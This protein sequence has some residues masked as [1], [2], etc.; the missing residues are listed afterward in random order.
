[1][2][3]LQCEQ[4]EDEALTLNPDP[5]VFRI[6]TAFPRLRLRSWLRRAAGP[7]QHSVELCLSLRIQVQAM[8]R[9]HIFDIV[10]RQI[11]LLWQ[12][13]FAK[14]QYTE[15]LSP[16]R[17]EFAERG[18]FNNLCS[19]PPT[20]SQPAQPKTHVFEITSSICKVSGPGGYPVN[21]HGCRYTRKW[22]PTTETEKQEEIL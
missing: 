11:H 3:K 8:S 1:M 12:V 21:Q 20:S 16:L 2:L 22:A 17:A 7:F 13:A 10:H 14:M 5:A 4:K 6:S 9:F 18:C 15:V 19:T